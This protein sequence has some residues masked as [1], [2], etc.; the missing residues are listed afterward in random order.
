MPEELIQSQIESLYPSY[1]KFVESEFAAQATLAFSEKMEFTQE[2]R[3]ILENAIVLYL[4]F[5]LD[6]NSFIDF[7]ARNCE[8]SS[9]DAT[10]L[11]NGILTS[12][13]PDLQTM[14]ESSYKTIHEERVE[15]TNVFASE[16]AQTEQEF[17]SIQG[18]RTMADD[19]RAVHPQ[20]EAVYR[21]SQAT[22][23]DRPVVPVVPR[24]PATP[25]QPLDSR[26]DTGQ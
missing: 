26:W 18:L 22:I 7:I 14:I 24:P 9:D 16:I 25:L 15:N 12:L 20:E 4:L 8:V 3:A 17:A 19:I 6:K 10:L 2:Q 11:V 13:P 21:S 23:L 1:R 5:F